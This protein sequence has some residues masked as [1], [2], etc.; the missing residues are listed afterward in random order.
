MLPASTG[1]GG[2]SMHGEAKLPART[3]APPTSSST[4]SIPLTGSR[5][6]GS[7][8]RALEMGGPGGHGGSPAAASIQTKPH[9]SASTVPTSMPLARSVT[10]APGSRPEPEVS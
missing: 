5:A 10:A 1:I 6:A 3:G 7:S 9:S 2:S 4:A 8:K